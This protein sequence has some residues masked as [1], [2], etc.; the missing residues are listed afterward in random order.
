MAS[1]SQYT[2]PIIIL[3]AGIALIT[4]WMMWV[5]PMLENDLDRFSQLDFYVGKSS[6]T[7]AIGDK[8]PDPTT[9]Y[10]IYSQNAS[11]VN[12]TTVRVDASFN[13]YDAATE[14]KLW[15][16]NSTNLVDKRTGKFVK[17]AD[18]YFRFPQDT[19]KQNYLVYLYSGIDPQPFVFQ[20]KATI[21]GLDVYKFSCKLTSDLT[22]S[23]PEFHPNTILSDYTCNSWVEPVTGNEVYYEENW[24]DYAVIDGKK[25]P[26]SIG[27]THTAQYAEEIIVEET[28]EKM[29][30]FDIYGKI[31]PVLFAVILA[32]IVIAIIA[33]QKQKQKII[34]ARIKR[35]KDEKLTIIGLLSSRLAHDIRNPLAVIKNGISLLKYEVADQKSQERFDMIDKAVSTITH[36][37]ND[38]M[39]FVRSKPL[40]IRENSI[41]DII[42]KSIKSLVI[43]E[44][45]TINIESSD[46]KAKCDSKQLEIVFNNLITNAMEAMN[47]Q[48]IVTINVREADGFAHIDI[49]DMGS[50]VPL[51]IMDKIFDPLFT[52]KQTGT[53]LG[54]VS[55]KN[56][57]EQHGGKITVANNPT[58]FTIILPKNL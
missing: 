12:S 10:S 14:K 36:Q 47:Y 25:I 27:N 43:P 57:V 45:V 52:T 33:Y 51:D 55:C 2:L 19:Q 53:G 21:E 22:D 44:T 37:I 54:L 46:I 40:V 26:V 18:T 41:I 34:E 58:T 31:M 20:D 3:V 8:M 28:R 56:I 23:Y 32:S 48:G 13:I 4:S 9:I 6:I 35:E 30:L 11:P 42:N 50:G 16:S 24:I 7:D 39:D 15:D 29:H 38:V 5:T 17:P 1:P 49:Q